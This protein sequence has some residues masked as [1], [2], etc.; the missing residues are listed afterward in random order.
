MRF[1]TETARE[2]GKRGGQLAGKKKPRPPR[3]FETI[4]ARRNVFSIWIRVADGN[5]LPVGEYRDLAVAVQYLAK[6]PDRLLKHRLDGFGKVH[7][8]Q[9]GKATVEWPGKT[10]LII[11]YL[12]GA[13]RICGRKKDRAPGVRKRV[14]VTCH[15]SNPVF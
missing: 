13:C 6:Y 3:F 7:I 5:I 15:E 11:W 2:N 10:P 8:Y 14:C 12:P 9:R 4:V 1:T